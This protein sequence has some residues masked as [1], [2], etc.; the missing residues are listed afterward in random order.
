[1][2]HSLKGRE[3]VKIRTR[4]A[5]SKTLRFSFFS[6]NNACSGQLLEKLKSK[7]GIGNTGIPITGKQ[8]PFLRREFLNTIF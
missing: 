5:L 4:P 8:K 2:A 3:V 7:G 6:R 1:M